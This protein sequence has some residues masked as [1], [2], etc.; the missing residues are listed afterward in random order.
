MLFRSDGPE[1]EK[2]RSRIATSALAD[3]VKFPGSID[4]KQTMKELKSSDIFLFCHKTL[5]SPRNLI[6]ALQCGLPLVGY[7][8]K[9]SQSLIEEN[10]GG[11][12]THSQDVTLLSNLLNA[13]NSDP[14]RIN[15]LSQKAVADGA[16]FTDEGVFKH[17]SNLMKTIP[18]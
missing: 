18:K 10:G 5:E 15:D 12:L 13:L 17:R 4:H 3:K 8:T 9:Y 1:L 11:A 7:G 6:E 14:V 2:A 16:R